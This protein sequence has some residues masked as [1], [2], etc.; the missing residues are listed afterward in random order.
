MGRPPRWQQAGALY[1]VVARGNNR[2]AIF[3]SDDDRKLYLK[4]FRLETDRHDFQRRT[5]CLMTNHVHLLMKSRLDNLP[6]LMER[7]HGAYA[8]YYNGKYKRVGHVFERRYYSGIVAG[9]EGLHAVGRYIHMNPVRAGIVARPED[10]RW[11]GFREC[12]GLDSFGLATVD[13][14]LRR[15][16]ERQSREE[17]YRYTVA[18]GEVPLPD[19]RWPPS[20]E[21]YMDPR[22]DADVAAAARVVERFAAAFGVSGDSLV[23]SRAARAVSARAAAA[24][25]LR[26]GKAWKLT[27]VAAAVGFSSAEAACNAIRRLRHQAAADP[28]LAESL[29]ALGLKATSD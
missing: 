21:W 13:D 9:T 26:D 14:L 19:D 2:E 7:F 12:L 16:V 11:S 15:P 28:S 5:Y 3:A 18:G 20:A 29:K 25:L 1:H 6:A 23:S 27:R 22:R 24:W 8:R 17:F 4:L 10:Y